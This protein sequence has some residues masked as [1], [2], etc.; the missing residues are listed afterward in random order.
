MRG[1]FVG[2]QGLTLP[3]LVVFRYTLKT[4]KTT[5]KLQQIQGFT[6]TRI[7]K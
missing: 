5:L 6:I 3:L 2:L 7:V 4:H 1:F